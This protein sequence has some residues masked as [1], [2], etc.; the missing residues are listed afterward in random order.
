MRFVQTWLSSAAY[1]GTAG[2]VASYSLTTVT[3]GGILRASITSVLSSSSCRSAFWN[4]E[5]SIWEYC[6]AAST[7]VEIR[8]VESVISFISSSVST[9]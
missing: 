4:G 6:L 8:V 5:R 2:S 3:P 7:S 1:D 9:V